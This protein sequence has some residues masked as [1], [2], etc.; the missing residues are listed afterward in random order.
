MTTR[1]RFVVLFLIIVSA[2]A[3][4]ACGSGGEPATSE[5]P[6]PEPPSPS[7]PST[8]E[9]AEA[10]VQIQALDSAGLAA[11]WG[12]GTVV[13]PD[14][15]ILT[16]AHVV[17]D[18]FDEYDVLGV[19]M[20]GQA[21]E[22]PELAYLAEIAAVDYTLDLAVIR[23][24][25]DLDGESVSLDLPFITTGDSDEVALGDHIRVLGF[26]G[27]GGETIT[28]TEGAVSGFTAEREIA[29]RAWIKTD[30]TTAGGNSGGLA[31]NDTGEL[32]GVPTIGGAGAEVE[33][34]VD[35]RYV[36]DT[37]RDGTI[38][39][40]DNC[41][42]VGGFINGLR[43]VNLALPLI[44]AVE[45][46]GTY[47]S[48]FPDV[49]PPM[50]GAFDLSGVIFRNLIFSAG[51]TEGDEPTQVMDFFFSGA[52]EA[53]AFWDYE[54]MANGL[55][56]EALWFIDGELDEAASFIDETW[57]GGESGNWWVCTVDERGLADGLYEIIISVEGE[58]QAG[59]AV[60][61][62]GDHPLV[63]IGLENLLSETVCYAFISPTGAQNWGMDKLG[64]EEGILP[65]DTA[66]F[67]VP[68]GTYD[69]LLEGCDQ[70]VLLEEYELS[71]SEAATYQ[72]T[73]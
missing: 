46:S 55:M 14:G 24:V 49:E 19:A 10:V 52:T 57:V 48:P 26:P 70:E 58:T 35:C 61:V 71:V 56:W 13:A 43:P 37:N 27:I 15:L 18:R 32:V 68:A 22:P 47:V 45:A 44:Q 11:W 69:L 33:E 9:L 41:V 4:A 25:S 3:A 72:I 50:N 8:G 23:I 17:D 6:S 1:L 31:A 62:G 36:V 64:P 28:F 30:A 67:F 12:S 65:G 53:C 16:N 21:D 42:P 2:L 34:F 73:E 59:D 66:T 5:S 29:N 39:D 63:D 60:F 7:P 38:D 51:V 40:L 54:G 20:T